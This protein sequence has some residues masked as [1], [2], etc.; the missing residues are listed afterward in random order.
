[1][2]GAERSP[3]RPQPDPASLPSAVPLR[4][5]LLSP[6]AGGAARRTGAAAARGARSRAGAMIQPRRSPSTSPSR[7]AAAARSP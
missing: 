1:M 5:L 3:G 2:L 7:P 6:S 4:R